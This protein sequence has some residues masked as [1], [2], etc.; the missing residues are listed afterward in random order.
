MKVVVDLQI[1]HPPKT[2]LLFSCCCSA[3]ID[4]TLEKSESPTLGEAEGP[5]GRALGEWFFT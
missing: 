5:T 1:S 4:G 3:E 2:A